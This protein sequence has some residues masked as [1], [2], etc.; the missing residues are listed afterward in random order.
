MVLMESHFITESMTLQAPV[1]VDIKRRVTV[2]VVSNILK[3]VNKY[4]LNTILRTVR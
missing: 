4:K 1:L 2:L 3:G